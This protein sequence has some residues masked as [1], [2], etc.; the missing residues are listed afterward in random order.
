LGKD[1]RRKRAVEITT[2]D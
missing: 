1:A 2:C